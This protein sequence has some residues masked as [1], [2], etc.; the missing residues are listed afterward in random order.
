M[1]GGDRTGPSGQGPLTGRRMGYCAGDDRPGYVFNTGYGY[2]R[3]RGRGLGLGR[4]F[5]HGFSQ[6]RGYRNF[7][8][9]NIPDVSEKT[10]LENEIRILKEQ[11]SSLENRLSKMEKKD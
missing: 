11:L 8:Q 9:E 4:G 3:G 10:L 1:P 2:G 6:E 7:Y 5:R